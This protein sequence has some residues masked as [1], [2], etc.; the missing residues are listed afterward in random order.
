MLAKQLKRLHQ[1]HM[2]DLT[3]LTHWLSSGCKGEGKG[4][5]GLWMDPATGQ[6]IIYQMERLETEKAQI[7]NY[8]LEKKPRTPAATNICKW[9]F[10]KT[11]PR[12]RRNRL[13]TITDNL[14]PGTV[15]IHSNLTRSC[16]DILWTLV[17]DCWSNIAIISTKV[18]FLSGCI[19]FIFHLQIR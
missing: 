6:T 16:P 5:I 8:T 1:S 2:F 13:G 12:A 9:L 14:S 3:C 17:L 18:K 15:N 11:S 4:G 19:D 7:S 10:R